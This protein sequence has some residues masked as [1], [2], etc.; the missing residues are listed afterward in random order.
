MNYCGGFTSPFYPS[1]KI[2]K[3]PDRF[4]KA[5]DL[6]YIKERLSGTVVIMDGLRYDL[7]LILKDVFIHEGWRIKEEVFMIDLP[8][9]SN[10]FRDA[11]GI[12]SDSGML[13]GKVYS[14]MEVAEREI[15]KRNLRKFL[16]EAQGIRFLHINFINARI[17][18]STLG[19]YLLYKKEVATATVP[20]RIRL[21]LSPI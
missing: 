2:M 12:G 10:N 15:G 20:I 21:F 7:W 14:I 5:K 4:N 19:L 11:I 13:D 17:H 1:S 9:T 16:K 8:S 3:K 6:G 18:S